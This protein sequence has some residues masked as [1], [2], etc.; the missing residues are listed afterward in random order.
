MYFKFI[1]VGFGE[2]NESPVGG[3]CLRDLTLQL[4][5]DRYVVRSQ[6][7]F[8]VPVRRREVSMDYKVI[9]DELVV[10]PAILVGVG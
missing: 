7:G 5:D 3:V 6:S 9:S 10:T 4:N 8:F 1:P 2:I